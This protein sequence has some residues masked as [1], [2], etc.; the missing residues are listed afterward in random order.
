MSSLDRAEHR[1]GGERM[2]SLAPVPFAPE[3]LNMPFRHGRP[4]GREE[5]DHGDVEFLKDIRQTV[6]SGR[7]VQT[8][9]VWV[10]SEG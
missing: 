3:E 8:D 10:R 2:T 5:I 6:V 9:P 1:F 7:S 4:E